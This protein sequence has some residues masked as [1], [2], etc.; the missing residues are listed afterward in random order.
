MVINVCTIYIPPAYA[1]TTCILICS[2]DLIAWSE[3]RAYSN[4]KILRNWG[5]PE[6]APH[7]S[8]Q[9]YISSVLLSHLRCV[10]YSVH[11][12]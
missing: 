4:R 11:L 9:H 2:K 7:Q 12:I 6:Q 10:T 3:I 8:Y 5:E 1:Y